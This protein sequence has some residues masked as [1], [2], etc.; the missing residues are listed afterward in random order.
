[1]KGMFYRKKLFMEKTRFF[2]AD[3]VKINGLHVVHTWR[4][5]QSE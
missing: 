2:S 3:Y 5:I 1:M 4:H